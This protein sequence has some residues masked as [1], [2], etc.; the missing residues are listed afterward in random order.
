VAVTVARRFDESQAQGLLEIEELFVVEIESNAEIVTDVAIEVRSG[1]TVGIVGESGSG[2]TTVALS[3]LGFARYGTR[4]VKG[5]VRVGGVDILACAEKERRAFRGRVAAFVPQDP[6]TSLNPAMRIERQLL[7][8]VDTHFGPTGTNWER[9]RRAC[10]DAQLPTEEEFLHRYPHQLSGGQQQRVCIA[11]ALVCDPKFIVMDEPTT[12]LDVTT[13]ARVL[14]VITL[15]KQSREVGILYVSH[16]LG[17]VRN[18]ADQVVVMYGGRVIESAR[19]S[20]LFEEPQHPYTRRLLEATPRVH[21]HGR[22]LRAIPGIAVQP[23]NRPPGCPFAPRC[24][25]RMERCNA[26][27]PPTEVSASRSVRCWRWQELP[28]R[29]SEAA[30][31]ILAELRDPDARSSRKS[32]STVRDVALEVEAL[33]AG[34]GNERSGVAD[35]PESEVL[36][37]VDVS[38][39][40]ERGRCFAIAG[41]S[42][43][44]KTTLLRCI[45][46]LHKPKAGRVMFAGTEVSSSAS[47]AAP[48]RR[49]IQLVPQNPDASLNP[50]HPVERI[51]GRPLE[52][53]F[54]LVHEPQRRRVAE[55]LEQVRLRPSVATRYPYELSGGEKQRVAIA[56]AMAAQPDV[57][58]CDEITA[59][60][61][62]AVQ[63][64]ILQLLGELR[65]NSN[66]TIVFVS[67]D[68][69]V[70]NVIA[71]GELLIMRRGEIQEQASAQQVLH[72][73]THEYTKELIAAI[74]ETRTT[75]YPHG[76]G[77]SRSTEA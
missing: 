73:P 23:R 38:F 39:K 35:P 54:G 51:V 44:G 62:V 12:G 75:D 17:V 76:F 19:A 4:I 77:V 30:E 2:K 29:G 53:F 3:A 25:Y 67:H 66:L 22:Q 71:D 49:L 42:G 64:G 40:V 5:S 70:V 33:S 46:G 55:L 11:M 13:Q 61:D 74:S 26:E 36:A 32:R 59:S 18:L 56:R 47:R 20:D 45:A 16:D 58:L 43:S 24:D 6:S 9:V 14:D 57:L 27:M 63:A 34:Y 50:R 37:L 68:L 60:L 72:H 41:E 65:Q 21:G 7:E 48:F 69:A 15:L 31:R 52:F 10:Q 8:T 1:E 28:R